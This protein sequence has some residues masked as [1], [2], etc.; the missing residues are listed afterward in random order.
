[1]N[2]LPS[3][4]L[5]NNIQLQQLNQLLQQR[6]SGLNRFVQYDNRPKEINRR[7]NYQQGSYPLQQYNQLRQP[8]FNR[9]VQFD[10]RSKE[11]NGNYNFLQGGYQQQQLN[12]MYQDRIPTFNKNIP[13]NNLI[14]NN[15]NLNLSPNG[16]QYIMI[17]I[18]T[19][20]IFLK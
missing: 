11:L 3:D 8:V 12:D 2:N 10:N 15:K 17:D 20:T 16:Y 9:F 6:Q 14:K 5:P 19:M 1:M 7:Y 4:I 18:E 13:Y